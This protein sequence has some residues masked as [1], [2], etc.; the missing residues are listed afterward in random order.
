M[1]EMEFDAQ[2]KAAI[3]AEGRRLL[4]ERPPFNPR[5]YGCLTFVVAA[6]LL[7]AL[8]Q[9]SKGL[10][11]MLPQPFGK[12]VVGVLVVALVGG[13]FAG[14]FLGSGV[15]G[16]AASR[17]SA[18][19]EWLAHPPGVTDPDARRRHAVTLV[20]NAMVT[21]GPTTT[22]TLAID[23]AR[24]KLG[25]NLQYVVAVERVLAAENLSYGHFGAH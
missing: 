9:L 1:A 23:E 5:P 2:E 25:E 16:R 10:G 18:S 7:V 20:L 15:Y 8:P 21:D 19:L 13:L 14:I 11:W 12:I 22:G 4:A 3:L 17:A 6:M 24:A